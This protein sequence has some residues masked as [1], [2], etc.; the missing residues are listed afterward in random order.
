[1][2]CYFSLKALFLSE[3][4]FSLFCCVTS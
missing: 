1:M 3:K 2:S 4:T